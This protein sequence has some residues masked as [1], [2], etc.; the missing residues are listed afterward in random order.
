MT[1]KRTIGYAAFMMGMT[2]APFDE[3]KCEK[4]GGTGY[5]PIFCCDGMHCGCRASAVDFKE[6]NCEYEKVSD[7]TIMSWIPDKYIRNR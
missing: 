2:N 3:D 7:E 4:C 1:E 5:I 6:C